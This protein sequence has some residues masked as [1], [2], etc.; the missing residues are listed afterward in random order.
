MNTKSLLE[1]LLRSGSELLQRKSSVNTGNAQQPYAKLPDQKSGSLSNTL[2]SMISGKGGAALAGGALGLLIGSKSGRKMGGKVLA[3]GGLAALGALAFKAYQN[4]QQE[5]PAQSQ[6]LDPVKPFDQLPAPQVEVH[7]KVILVALI[8]A[9]KADGHIDERERELIDSELAKLTS[10]P[11]L[12][13]WVEC[14]LKKP[15]DPAEIASHAKNQ[16]MAAEMYLASLLTIDEQNFMEKSYLQELA[17]QLKLDPPLQEQ[18]AL[19][20]RQAIAVAN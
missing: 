4:Y 18:L 15:L 12:Q 2:S 17:R 13:Q 1:Q 8:A 11:S 19:Q 6:Q 3:Y 7:C 9:A 16:A 14:E 20:V 5:N 10:D